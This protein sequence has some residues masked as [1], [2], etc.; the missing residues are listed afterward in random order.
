MINKQLLNTYSRLKRRVLLLVEDINFCRACLKNKVIPNFIRVSC[1]V[2]NTRTCKVIEYA[3]FKWLRNEIKYLFSKLND[4]ELELYNIHLLIG[5]NIEVQLF[6][7][8]INFQ[9]MVFN[10][11][12]SVVKKKRDIHYKKLQFLLNEK[13]KKLNKTHEPKFIDDFVVNLSKQTFNENEL[14]LLNKGLKYTPKSNRTNVF[15]SIVDIETSI[16]FKLPSAQNQIRKKS[17]QVIEEV[18]NEENNKKEKRNIEFNTIKSLKE[19]NCVYV[20]ADKGNKVVILDNEDYDT[21]I[22]DL[23]NEC[24]YLKLKRDP[25]P[26]MIRESDKIRQQIGK[27]FGYR[28]LR[29]L[30]VS[31]PSVAKIYG[32]PKIHKFGN[33]MRPI[34]S[35]IGTPSYK[36]AK[37]LIGEIKK[38]PKFESL[39]V[40]NVFDFTEKV[41]NQIINNNEIMVSF[42]V[43]SLFPS[44]DVNYALMEFEKYLYEMNISNSKKEVYSNVAKMCM[45]QNYFQF[46]NEFYKVEKGTNMGNPLSPLISE[47]FMS[48]LERQLKKQ[49]L[50]PRVW[51]RYVDDIFA[52][53]NEADIENTLNILNS[54][55]ESIKFTLEKEENKKLA[56]LDVQVCRKSDNSL[57]FSVY[58]KPTST[59][60]VI[61]SDSFCHFQYKKSSFHSM[62][63]RMCKLPLSITAYKSEYEYIKD[64][65]VLNGYPIDIV[66]SLIKEH[67]K[68]IKRRNFTTF[69][70]SVEKGKELVR[71]AMSYEPKITLKLKQVYSE[72]N[73]CIVHRNDNKLSNLLG[74][75]K[76]KTENMKKSGIYR[77]QCNDCDCVYIGQ[78]RRKIETRFKEHLKCIKEKDKIHSAFAKHILENEHS[79]VSI[80]NV[81]L[82]KQVNFQNKL[83]AYE[84]CFIHSHR[85]T[86][87]LD[88]GNIDSFL[89][90]LI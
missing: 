51:F 18:L 68:R 1:A 46:R 49:N 63:Y 32:L 64:V 81:H 20:K 69:Y 48:A 79:L 84:C 77:I 4:F 74:N 57:E 78:T 38:L 60:R 23:I 5:K 36:I 87:N 59:K 35:S 43:V 15:E 61:T 19:K 44:I 26:S 82:L 10:R 31:N 83:D 28:T 30:L 7:F 25:L 2:Q 55:F 6:D 13:K 73:M 8:W 70:S 40:K 11:I 16:K 33:K 66:D 12:H 62:I 88:N 75:T 53:L 14:N 72:N 42:D 71:V 76:D 50:L 34:V 54:Q 67:S 58:H 39:A 17:K 27:V 90:D 47:C 22:F 3:Q 37:W 65:A 41:K 9:S 29:N 80:D 86:V 45:K 85:N 52:I 89:F 24:G 21:R 56:F